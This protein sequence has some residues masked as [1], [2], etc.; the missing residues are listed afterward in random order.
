M[1]LPAAL[2]RFLTA[3]EARDAEAA[4]ACFAD[5]APYAN[6]PHPPVVGPA[7]V[8]DLLAPILERSEH[9][10]W[11]IVTAA[12][13]PRRCFLERVDRFVI[14]GREYAVACTAVVE[15][16]PE[17]DRI[18]AFRDY[19]DLGEWRARLAGALS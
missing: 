7:G 4:G 10:R 16:D 12:V 15:I 9:V 11:E 2:A 6:V 8:R 17:A 18:T 13:D 5:G 1:D 3:V 14:D 19:V